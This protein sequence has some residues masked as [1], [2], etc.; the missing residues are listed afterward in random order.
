MLEACELI[1]ESW[2]LTGD[3][4][5]EQITITVGNQQ[6]ILAP[7]VGQSDAVPSFQHTNRVH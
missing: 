5:T 2:A 3:P 1:E 6:I 7:P 4:E